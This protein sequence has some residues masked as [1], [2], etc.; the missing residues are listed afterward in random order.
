MGRRPVEALLAIVLSIT[1]TLPVEIIH[2]VYKNP[3]VGLT[4]AEPRVAGII[5]VIPKN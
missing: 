2:I 5:E 4:G 1:K 3:N